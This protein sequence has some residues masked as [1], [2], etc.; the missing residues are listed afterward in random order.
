MTFLSQTGA[1]SVGVAWWSVRAAMKAATLQAN[2]SREAAMMVIEDDHRKDREAYE[3]HRYAFAR[4][5]ASDLDKLTTAIEG[6]K[7]DDSL[8]GATL[9][10]RS[11]VGQVLRL[12]EPPNFITR[13]DELELLDTTVQADIA[14]LLEATRN[15]N[16]G[17]DT[18]AGALERP[19]RSPAT[20]RR[21][22]RPS[23]APRKPSP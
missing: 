21:S 6:I 16:A 10:I 19:R 23:T 4:A 13:W 8:R 22:S 17:V 3:R 2:A 1:S 18:A 7:A 15:D 9:L 11:D 14:E 5:I 20:W 12:P